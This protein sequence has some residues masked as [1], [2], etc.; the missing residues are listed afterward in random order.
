[1]DTVKIMDSNGLFKKELDTGYW[2]S[3]SPDGQRILYLKNGTTLSV[4]DVD[5][6]NQIDLIDLSD[7]LFTSSEDAETREK[8]LYSNSRSINFPAFSPSGQQVL[9]TV[10]LASASAYESNYR[11]YLYDMN[12]SELTLLAVM[13][14][15]PTN[16]RFYYDRNYRRPVVVSPDGNQVFYFDDNIC[17]INVDGSNR[18]VLEG[19]DC[20]MF[21]LSPDGEDIYFLQSVEQENPDSQ[22]RLC[23]IRADG[24]SRVVLADDCTSDS[25]VALSSDGKKITFV[26]GQNSEQRNLITMN[27]DGSD[28]KLVTSLG[29]AGKLEGEL[30]AVRFTPNGKQLILEIRKPTGAVCTTDLYA[31]DVDG[32]NLIQFTHA[33]PDLIYNFDDFSPYGWE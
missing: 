28:R 4:I 2:P 19:T 7:I 3:F 16:N 10:V 6:T 32:K 12:T 13:E 29:G 5:G 21:I 14:Q 17:V 15:D 30:K 22:M 20:E 8:I 18:T 1:M 25:L 27:V 26:V 11:I 31:I 9:F 24:S 33:E 23:T